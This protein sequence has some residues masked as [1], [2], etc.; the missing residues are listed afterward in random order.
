MI[1]CYDFCGH[2]DWTF[3]WLLRTGGEPL[4][5]RYWEESISGDSQRH[6][7]ELIN[8]EG[9]EGMR[10]YWA[11]TLEEEAAGYALS[12]NANTVRID[13]HECPSK[14]FLI[15]NQLE[16]YHDYCNHCIG[17]IGPVMKNAGFT[18]DHEHNHCGQC[19]W[20]FRKKDDPTPASPSGALAGEKDV[21]FGADWDQAGVPHD[22]FLR[23]TSPDEKTKS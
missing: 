4:V 21:R 18:I 15:Q 16:T 17:W 6:A 2:Y 20:E 19:W 14:G 13:M 8:A 1:G 11:H 9:F 12:S 10:K 7:A 22:V 23:A 3:E 5:H